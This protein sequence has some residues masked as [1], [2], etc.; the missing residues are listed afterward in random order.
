MEFLIFD[1]AVISIKLPY[2]TKMLD[3]NMVDELYK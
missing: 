2:K 3:D 1:V